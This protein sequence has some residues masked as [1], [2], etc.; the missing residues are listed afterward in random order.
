MSYGYSPEGVLRDSNG[1]VT[2]K[3]DQW[4]PG[5]ARPRSRWSAGLP[6]GVDQGRGCG[7][8]QPT[9]Q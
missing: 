8:P 9:V 6:K 5:A 7:V 1:V 2:V 3:V 4:F